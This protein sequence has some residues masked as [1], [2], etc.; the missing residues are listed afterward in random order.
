MSPP[1]AAPPV[2]RGVE[3]EPKKQPDPWQD[4]HA[5]GVEGSI[6]ASG[7]IGASSIEPSEEE[8][9]G[10]GFD[11]ST[12]L[13]L[14]TEYLL[15]FGLT[16]ASLGSVQTASGV[17]EFKG[18]YSVTATYLGARAFPWRRPNAEIF[19]GL[20][21][22]LAWQGIDATGVRSPPDVWDP[23]PFACSGTAGPGVAL[24][25]GIG[26]ALRLGSR[27]WLTGHLDANGYKMTSEVIDDCAVGIGSVTN[28]SF[29]AGI[30]YAFD[31]GRDAKLEAAKPSSTQTW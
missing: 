4:A 28:A 5:L 16:Y 30:L 10:V 6:Y 26:G 12:W 23:Q 18:A 17:N 3:K 14:S 29:G 8:R 31:L 2:D 24:G 21:V 1:P 22:G 25:A 7:R 11:L 27:A 13:T 20:R 9:F 19:V 15:G